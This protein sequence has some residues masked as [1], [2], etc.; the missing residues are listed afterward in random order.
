MLQVRVYSHLFTVEEPSDAGWEAE[1]NPESETVLLAARVD[2]SI[3]NWNPKVESSFQVQ[4]IN[5]FF[6]V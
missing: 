5:S 4:C 3:M 6:D 1:L 2:P